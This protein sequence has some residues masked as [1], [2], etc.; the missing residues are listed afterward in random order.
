MKKNTVL[1]HKNLQAPKSPQHYALHA[2]KHSKETKKLTSNS[3]NKNQ[4]GKTLFK[5]QSK[6]KNLR[7]SQ[8]PPEK[9]LKQKSQRKN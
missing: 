5:S 3:N 1:F 9:L 4:S 7:G 8:S 2:I 6:N